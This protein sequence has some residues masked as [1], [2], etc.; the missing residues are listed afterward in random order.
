MALHT[1]QVPVNKSAYVD[2][3]NGSTNYGTLQYIRAGEYNDP[4][5][6]YIR[7]FSLF[8]WDTSLIPSGKRIVSAILYLYSKKAYTRSSG[9]SLKHIYNTGA[10]AENTVTF[11]NAPIYTS[12]FYGSPY[13]YTGDIAANTYFAYT[14][15]PETVFMPNG[16]TLAIDGTDYA[17]FN[18]SRAASNKPYLEVTYEDVPPDAPTPKEPIGLYKDSKGIIRFEWQYVSSVGGAQKKVDLQWSTDQINWTTISQ[19]TADN[20]YDM[21]ANTLPAGNIYWRIRC[22][23]DYDEVGPYCAAQSFY[24]IGAPATPAINPVQTNSARP[25]ISWSAFGQQIYQLQVLSGETVVYDSG[26]QPSISIRQHKV[27][28]WLSDG[29]YTVKIHVKNEYGLW[30]AWGQTNVIITTVKPAKPV[31]SV[32]KTNYVL[33]AKAIVNGADYALLYRDGVC[34]EKQTTKSIVDDNGLVVENLLGGDGDCENLNSAS[35]GK[36]VITLDSSVKVFGSS[37]F[38]ITTDTSNDYHSYFYSKGGVTTVNITEYG[39]AVGDYISISGYFKTS[40]GKARLY[41]L[42]FDANSVQLSSTYVVAS[43]PSGFTRY[44]KRAVI[45]A[46]TAKIRF[47]VTLLDDL[48][49]A[50]FAGNGE[51]TNVDGLMVQKITAADYALSDSDFLTKYPFGNREAFI[52]DDNTAA[53]GSAHAYKARL[54]QN[55]PE[56]QVKNLLASVGDCENLNDFV[57]ARITSN[58]DASNKL[59]G[60]N[61]I[62]IT[63]DNQMGYHLIQCKL[64]GVTKIP[65]S[66]LGLSVDNYIMLSAYLKVNVGCGKIQILFYDASGVQ[67]SSPSSDLATVAPA[68]FTR[69]SLKTQ[70]PALAD[71]LL[72]QIVLTNSSGVS[73]FTGTTENMNLDGI[74]LQGISA[75]DYWNLNFDQLFAKY[76]YGNNTFTAPA[77]EVYSD[78]DPVTEMADFKSALIAPVSDLTN[79]FAFALS[80][81]SAPKRVYDRSPGGAM[82]QYAGRRHPVWEPDEHMSVGLSCGAFFLETWAEVEAFEAIYDLNGTVLYRDA[83]GR[84][85]YGKLTNLQVNE[86][87]LGYTISFVINQVDYDEELEV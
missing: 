30:S 72:V 31:F 16:I 20:Y 26:N 80:L 84:K 64:N 79:V 46:N 10:W 25:I 78:S 53:N 42:F 85:I 58:L 60:S 9:G 35:S 73:N 74:M 62:K 48:G 1:I 71:S 50:V 28:A 75:I 33:Q 4:T 21:P 36:V 87:R 23:N 70:I 15:N 17:E 45:P 55:I 29:L 37:S 24:A 83:K 22:Y 86:E 40:K 34:I 61:S 54:V 39:L 27:M 43:S 59:F 49:N 67:I 44:V 68:Q 12:F 66:A 5:Y 52:I 18:S 77:Y 3:T 32:A 7:Y 47:Q 11:N 51:N 57:N 63:T 76:P 69:I 8:G 6:L 2:R 56:R 81:N 13:M 19:T 38:K 82:V 65:I 41:M 14:I